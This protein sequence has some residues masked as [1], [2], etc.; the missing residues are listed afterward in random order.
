LTGLTINGI[1]KI[2]R[3][4]ILNP[5]SDTMEALQKV[6]ESNDI[7]FLPN[8][9]VARY[10]DI[11]DKLTGPRAINQLLQDV[12]ETVKGGGTVC[13][14]GVNETTFDKFYVDDET[15]SHKA[16]MIGIKDNVKC[17]EIICEGDTN[18][19][20]DSYIEYRWM[21]QERFKEN[22]FYVYNQKLAFIKFDNDSP[23]V[24]RINMPSIAFAFRDLFDIVWEQCKVPP[25]HKG[26]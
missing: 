13:V 3:G 2:E 16:R 14:S 23:E 18:Y 26:G 9:G 24:W 25:R 6:F 7:Q 11:I 5:R 22:P 15:P 19:T 20:Y 8:D 12:Y 4:Y 10:R 17:R 21:A 1:S